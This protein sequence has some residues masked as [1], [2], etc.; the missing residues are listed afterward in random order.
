MTRKSRRRFLEGLGVAAAVG[1]VPE[2]EA[3]A[4]P[5]M[6]M[7]EAGERRQRLAAALRA[8]NEAGGLGVTGE[9]LDRAEAYATGALLEAE[10]RLRPL[11]FP[12]SLDLPVV[13]KARRRP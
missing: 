6:S 10:A 2:A 8:L 12:E 9:D 3:Q 13:F 4:P 5:K 1:R 7:D 11:V